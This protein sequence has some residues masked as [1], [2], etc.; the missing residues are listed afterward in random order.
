MRIGLIGLGALVLLGCSA[1]G[2]SGLAI[3]CSAADRTGTYLQRFETLSG[4]CGDIPEALG[5]VD[6][7]LPATCTL[8]APD[9]LS[10]GECKLERAYTC[11]AD[12][13]GATAKY[14]AVSTQEADDGSRLV[15]TLSVRGL[16]ADG[17]LACSGT[18]RITATRQ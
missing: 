17:T 1:G 6:A 3:T 14:V 5:R 9:R 18:Y 12:A 13:A 4:D 7:G 2:E 11:Q 10:E 16:N 15:G 8:D